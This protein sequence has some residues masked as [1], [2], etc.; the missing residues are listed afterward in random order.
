MRQADAK[1]A[2][3]R[4]VVSVLLRAL[5]PPIEGKRQAGWLVGR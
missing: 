2:A 5:M 4:S 3:F 1:H